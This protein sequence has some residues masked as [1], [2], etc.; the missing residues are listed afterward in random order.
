MNQQLEEISQ[1][2]FEINSPFT[3]HQVLNDQKIACDFIEWVLLK[4]DYRLVRIFPQNNELRLQSLT[5]TVASLG[6]CKITDTDLIDATAPHFRL[7]NFYFNLLNIL[8]TSRIIL[9]DTFKIPNSI[10]PD[11]FKKSCYLIDSISKECDLVNKIV[12]KEFG[13][14]P[15]D[16][17]LMI[18]KEKAV[19]SDKHKLDL[20]TLQS[21]KGKKIQELQALNAE[22]NCIQEQEAC[23]YLD[24]PDVNEQTH[25]DLSVIASDLSSKFKKFNEIYDNE[26]SPWIKKDYIK[27]DGDKIAEG[28]GHRVQEANKRLC[29]IRKSLQDFETIQK[30]YE[31]IVSH[32]PCT[33]DQHNSVNNNTSSTGNDITNSAVN[34]NIIN[35]RGEPGLEAITRL[36]KFEKILK[37][38]IERRAK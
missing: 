8:K 32:L 37:D 1:K 35:N 38:G 22:S 16:V 20:S 36:Q 25:E 2:F 29:K 14:F 30:S 17:L 10:K 15:R 23:L 19:E 24:E 33:I 21:M 4:I 28:L 34:P 18:G 12:S 3:F 7:I 5:Q 9:D 13:L 26:I 27:R 11:D 31:E 6:I